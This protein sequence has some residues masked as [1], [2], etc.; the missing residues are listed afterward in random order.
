V[1]VDIED[2]LNATE[3]AALL[4]LSQRQAISTYRGRY[5]DFPKPVINKGTCVLW[6]RADVEAWDKTRLR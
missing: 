6:L 4:G 5:P 1:T 3:V 2:L